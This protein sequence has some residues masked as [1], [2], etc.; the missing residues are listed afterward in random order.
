MPASLSA[1]PKA[2]LK[3][4]NTHSDFFKRIAPIVSANFRIQRTRWNPN[5]D[6]IA[7]RR[8]QRNA[9]EGLGNLNH[10]TEEKFA[11]ERGKAVDG[12]Q[13]AAWMTKVWK[14]STGKS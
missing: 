10:R 9:Q 6:A 3:P 11:P 4:L 2:T 13:M 8:S 7:D 14:K 12:L 1:H 5:A